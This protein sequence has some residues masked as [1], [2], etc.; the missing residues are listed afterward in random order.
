[1]EIHGKMHKGP[2]PEPQILLQYDQISPGAA[3]RIIKMAEQQ[4]CHR[5]KLELIVIKSGAR[6]SLLGLIFGLI[7]GL[8]TVVG[9][10]LSI[11]K[12]YQGGGA[13]L[14]ISGIA[15]L[16]GVFVYGSRQRR[17][18]REMKMRAPQEG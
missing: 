11:S 14:G 7:I 16:V 8:A 3:D 13:T 17:Q 18:E 2:L 12:G 4:S 1:M 9:A 10:V 15:G 5:Q 6:D